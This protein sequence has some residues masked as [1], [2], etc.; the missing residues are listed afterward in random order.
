MSETLVLQCDY[1]DFLKISL[2]YMGLAP[3]TKYFEFDVKGSIKMTIQAILN[4]LLLINQEQGVPQKSVLGPLLFSA[5][6]S[7]VDAFICGYCSGKANLSDE[8][9]KDCFLEVRTTICPVPE[10]I[11]GFYVSITGK[12]GRLIKITRICT[13]NR[14]NRKYK[15][16]KS[17]GKN[18]V[19]GFYY[20]RKEKS[21]CKELTTMFEKSDIKKHFSPKS[22][23]YNFLV[24]KWKNA[25]CKENKKYPGLDPDEIPD[26]EEGPDDGDELSGDGIG[27]L[28]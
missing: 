17:E 13:S 10:N 20:S 11:C 4:F 7:P 5:Y 28:S 2:T 12:L 14:E 19:R 18:E 15:L 16:E 9:P 1:N 26:D 8:V 24:K 6:I 3:S 22:K 27:S 21:N 23:A 25:S